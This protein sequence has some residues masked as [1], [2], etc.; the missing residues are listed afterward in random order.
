MNIKFF[1]AI[2]SI[3]V[4]LSGTSAPAWANAPTIDQ[5]VANPKMLTAELDRC[6]R[7]GMAANEDAR[8]H[9]AWNAENK[10]FFGHAPTY[11]QKSV[12]VF[13]GT[14]AYVSPVIPG[15]RK[16]PSSHHAPAAPPNG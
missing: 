16:S 2:S 5:L 7:L 15:P 10:Q 3:V 8:C 9:T 14:P 6:Q 12:N 4:G 11:T 13:P 1:A